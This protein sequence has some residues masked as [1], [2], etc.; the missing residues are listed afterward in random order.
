ML[1][2]IIQ[3]H[4]AAPPARL[5]NDVH[6][7]GAAHLCRNC[8]HLP[9]LA[10]GKFLTFEMRAQTARP[11]V[12][13]IDGDSAAGADVAVKGTFLARDPGQT[14]QSFQMRRSD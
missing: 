5:K 2:E 9:A 7:A 12:I 11:W 1:A 10:I 13:E 14:I 8:A 4:F 3:A 6:S